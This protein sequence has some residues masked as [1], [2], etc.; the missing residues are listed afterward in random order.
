MSEDKLR[1]DIQRGE[2][3][4]AIIDDGLLTEAFATLRKQYSET[5]FMTTPL[6]SATRE[7]L[8]IAFNVIGKVE[9][10]LNTVLTDGKLARAQ[11]D[12]D[13]EVEKRKAKSK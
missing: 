13:L 6:D 2:R 4:K 5:L 10:H 3:A 7:K 11:I 9:E 8:Y 1:E 12:R